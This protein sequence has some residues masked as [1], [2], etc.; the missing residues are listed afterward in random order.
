MTAAERCHLCQIEVVPGAFTVSEDG[1]A[2]CIDWERRNGCARR[3][4]GVRPG[5]PAP[6]S[7]TTGSVPS[8]IAAVE[9]TTRRPVTG[10]GVTS[11]IAAT[12]RVLG[13]PR[14]LSP[15]PNP[16]TNSPHH[17]TIRKHP[18]YPGSKDEARRN[19]ALRTRLESDPD[20][21]DE[22]RGRLEGEPDDEK[23]N[24]DAS[25]CS[26]ERH[27]S[28]ESGHPVSASPN[29]DHLSNSVRRVSCERP[30]ASPP[31]RYQGRA[32]TRAPAP[33]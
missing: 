16:F 10:Q 33:M 25:L 7:D 24:A 8:Q 4:P 6:R 30:C 26:A 21:A 2:L 15:R 19:P 31:R 22:E 32:R 11:V 18:E 28:R 13:R 29:R 1:W 17:Y 23:G 9:S 27:L 12:C 14:G 3:R 5:R 20:A